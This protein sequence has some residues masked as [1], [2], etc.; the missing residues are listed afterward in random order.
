MKFFFIVVFLP[1]ILVILYTNIVFQTLQTQLNKM[2]Q[3]FL[4]HFVS[5][6][7][8]TQF[9]VKLVYNSRDHTVG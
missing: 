6:K 8:A 3:N 5:K 7:N 1:L 2:V 4:T 9:Q